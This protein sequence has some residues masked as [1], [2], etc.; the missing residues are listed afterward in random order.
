MLPRTVASKLIMEGLG[1]LV[2]VLVDV[3][4]LEVVASR[5]QS[6]PNA[7]LIQSPFDSIGQDGDTSAHA[8]RTLNVAPEGVKVRV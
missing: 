3:D 6:T 7:N 8:G 1:C 5:A 2:G 4:F